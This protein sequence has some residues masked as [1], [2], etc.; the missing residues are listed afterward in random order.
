M[1]KDCTGL[2]TTELVGILIKKN[3]GI[4]VTNVASN[5]KISFYFL[6]RAKKAQER[7]RKTHENIKRRF[8]MFKL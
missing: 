6:S 4:N 1:T 8:V 2:N 7:T 5:V 3:I